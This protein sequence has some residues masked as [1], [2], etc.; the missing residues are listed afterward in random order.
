MRSAARLG[1]RVTGALTAIAA[2]LS[3][4]CASTIQVDERGRSVIHGFGYVAVVLPPTFST[5]DAAGDPIEFSSVGV[6]TLGLQ[7][8]SGGVTLGYASSGRLH[9]PLDCRFVAVVQDR[10]QLEHLTETLEPLR[11]EPLCISVSPD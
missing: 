3:P 11:G 4:G 9:V 6:R 7:V 5:A 10:A 8:R 2:L 1:F